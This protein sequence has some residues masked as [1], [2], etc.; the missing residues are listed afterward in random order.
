MPATFSKQKRLQFTNAVVTIHDF[1]C[2]CDHPVT[3]S[4]KQLLA[5]VKEE[6]TAEEKKEIEKCLGDSTAAKDGEDDGLH[7]GDDL[8]TIFADD[9]ADEG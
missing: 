4:T 8:E 1:C 3:C 2:D 9:F 5:Q 7:F 6:I